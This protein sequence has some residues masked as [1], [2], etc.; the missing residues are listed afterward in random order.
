MKSLQQPRFAVLNGYGATP[1]YSV[2]EICGCQYTLINVAK[3]W[4]M[5][6]VSVV[7]YDYINKLEPIK[8]ELKL[9]SQHDSLEV[10]C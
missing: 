6:H 8:E 10:D 9:F 7:L 5:K 2:I 4:G 1:G 3:H